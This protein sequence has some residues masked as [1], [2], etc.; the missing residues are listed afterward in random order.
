[1]KDRIQDVWLVGKENANDGYRIVVREEDSQFG[2]ASPGFGND[3]HLILTG[4]YGSLKAAFLA[5]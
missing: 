1:L 5:M 3:K 4:W 2:L